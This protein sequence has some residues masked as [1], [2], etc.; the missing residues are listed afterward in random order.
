MA[1]GDLDFLDSLRSAVCAE[2]YPEYSADAF[3][4]GVCFGLLRAVF[5]GDED[6]ILDEAAS[7]RLVFLNL[8]V[9]HEAV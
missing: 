1:A 8:G 4:L 9:R 3:L 6:R 2:N 7:V 5:S